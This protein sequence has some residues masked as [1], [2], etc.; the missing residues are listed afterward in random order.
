MQPTVYDFDVV[1]IGAGHAGTEAAAAAARMG[2]QVAL[3]TTNLDTVGQM[4]CIQ[5]SE[6]SPKGI[7]SEKLT[8]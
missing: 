5:P 1:V 8:L 2:A 7:S 3:L 6:A 4:S